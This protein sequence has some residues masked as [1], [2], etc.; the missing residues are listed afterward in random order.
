MNLRYYIAHVA[1][2]GRGS[3]V[4]LGYFVACLAVGVCAVVVVAGLTQSLKSGIRDG[5]KELL[6]ADLA[7]S[8]RETP[9][10]DLDDFLADTAF[11]G[12]ADVRDRPIAVA[13]VAGKSI[14][15]ELKVVKGEYPFYGSLDLVPNRPLADLLA[16]DTT[17]VAPDVLSRLELKQGDTLRIG[18]EDFRIAGVARTEPDRITGAMYIGPR[19]FL[20]HDAAAQ[21]SIGAMGTRVRYKT[22]LKFPET[23]TAARLE[24]EAAS[25]RDSMSHVPSVRVETYTQGRPSLQRRLNRL[26]HYLSLIALLSLLLGGVG[27]AQAVRSWIEGRLDSI[28]VL[29]CVGMR[30]REVFILYLSQAVLMGFLGSLVGAALGAAL[31]YAV[32]P[33]FKEHIPTNFIS[34]WQPWAYVRGIGLGMSVAILFC[35]PPLVAVLRVPPA[36]VLRRNA[37]PL[38]EARWVPWATVSLA[39]VGVGALATYQ[40]ESTALGLQFMGGVLVTGLTLGL[41]ALGLSRVAAYVPRDLGRRVWLRHGLAALAR[42]GASTVAS[43]VGLGL[44]LLVLFCSVLVQRHLNAQLESELPTKAPSAFMIDVRPHQWEGLKELLEEE[45]AREIQTVPMIMARITAVDGEEV[46]QEKDDERRHWHHRELRRQQRLTYMQSLP[47]DNRILRGALWSDPDRYE[48]SL[49]EGF[50]RRQN[51]DVGTELSFNVWGEN[52]DFVVTSI[53]SVEWESFNLNFELVAEP[54]VL[55]D[56]PQLRLVTVRLPDGRGQAVQDEVVARYPNVTFVQVS[57]ILERATL[58]LTRIGWGVR[59][60]GLFIIGAGIAVLIGTVGVQA[61]RRGREVALL[62]TLGMTRRQVIGVFAT[63]YALI[64]L[65]AGIIGVTGGGTLAWLAITRG[66]E[67]EWKFE[68]ELF[69]I[70]LI[71]GTGLAVI[72]GI[73]ASIGALRN[74]PIEVLRHEQ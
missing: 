12:R 62:K 50:A 47:P 36:R 4:R 52:I 17:V 7:I 63:E 3:G 9:P 67:I 15:A 64:G 57:E 21:T 53:R 31:L 22:L 38:P 6:G 39:I 68:G 20:S 56:V 72:A 66:L 74:P 23:V 51:F 58:Q 8:F 59:I 27:V 19:V 48:L 73:G 33:F 65:V 34:A 71:A 2:E 54:G 45:G 61:Q 37:E 10:D 32:P 13:T 11:V 18:G 55:D 49:E 70:A 30:P 43:M 60:V 42:P 35:V 41:A 25:L 5:A 29:K 16:A 28:A 26:E 14:I 44:G 40:A 46:R 1:R 69:L 24:E